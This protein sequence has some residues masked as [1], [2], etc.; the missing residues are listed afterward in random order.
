MND[1]ITSMKDY[2]DQAEAE[3][4]ATNGRLA[5]LER[6][7]QERDVVVDEMSRGLETAWDRIV[8]HKQSLVIS[9]PFLRGLLLVTGAAGG[10]AGAGGAG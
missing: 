6:A 5:S 2:F 9:R 7:V 8:I 1:R 4:A 3:R 10:E